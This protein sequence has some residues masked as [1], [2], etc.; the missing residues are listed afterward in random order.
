MGSEREKRFRRGMA[1]YEIVS[2]LERREKYELC[3]QNK[4][5]GKQVTQMN[6]TIDELIKDGKS[7]G[8]IKQTIRKMYPELS[9]KMENIKIPVISTRGLKNR[10]FQIAKNKEEQLEMEQ[11][12][13]QIVN[14]IDQGKSP[15][16]I[17]EM[18]GKQYPK[19]IEDLRRMP[20]PNEETDRLTVQ[21]QDRV[22]R[23]RNKL[24]VHEVDNGS[25]R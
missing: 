1:V 23:F 2:D 15:E 13:H 17:R 16:E 21:L 12:F 9:E 25:A 6:E 4:E 22:E 10:L 19:L 18:I 3:R 8:A 11:I 7:S 24:P 5:K 14:L 20:L